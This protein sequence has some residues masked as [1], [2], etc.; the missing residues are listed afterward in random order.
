MIGHEDYE[1]D[2]VSLQ[3][4]NLSPT[5][6]INNM[7]SL[8]TSFDTTL[9]DPTPLNTRNPNFGASMLEDSKHRVNKGFRVS[10]I[11]G[12]THSYSYRTSLLEFFTNTAK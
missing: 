8:S 4:V 6:E 5:E 7:D 12:P 3:I 2:F 10:E 9:A 1:F 11:W